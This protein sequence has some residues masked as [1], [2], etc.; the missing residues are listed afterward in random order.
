MNLREVRRS[1]IEP[2]LLLLPAK[3]DSPQAIVMLLAITRQE[4]PE[5]RR[6]QWP[7]GP[8]RSLWQAEQGGGM[9]TGLLRYRVDSIRDWATGLCVVRGIAPAAPEVWKAI[10][11]DDILAAGLARL[12]LYTDPARLPELGDEVGA[13]D[14]Y[15]RTWRPG[16]YTRGDAAQRA[17]LR[18]KWS[19]NY[20]AALEVA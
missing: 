15:L 1:I 9:I 6:R 8:A 14:L 3:M 4:D 5:Q 2:A 20:A 17:G 16:A 18:A 11:H 10:E 13:W 19:R 7:T 12:L